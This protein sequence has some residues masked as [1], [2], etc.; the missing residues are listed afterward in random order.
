MKSLTGSLLGT[1]F[2]LALLVPVHGAASQETCSEGSSD[3]RVD[4]LVRL[5][6]ELRLEMQRGVADLTIESQRV[7]TKFDKDLRDAKRVIQESIAEQTARVDGIEIQLG[8]GLEEVKSEI[9]TAVGNL[10]GDEM[11][12]A[13]NTLAGGLEA[14]TEDV[15]VLKNMAATAREVQ[16]TLR[17]DIE[18]G[19]AGLTENIEGILREIQ[20]RE[21]AF[22]IAVGQLN[23]RLDELGSSTRAAGIRFGSGGNEDFGAGETLTLDVTPDSV[24]F[25]TAEARVSP[26]STEPFAITPQ[27]ALHQKCDIAS[28]GPRVGRRVTVSC[29][30]GGLDSGAITISGADLR[31]EN[32]YRYFVLT[33]N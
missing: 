14:L 18:S 27:S 3:E 20:E 21:S 26:R 24:V 29:T 13:V 19:V 28:V 30:F 9:Q 10:R 4:C 16:V 22:S 15:R 6:T 23:V 11:R 8:A 5:V 1:A 2:A 32:S 25:V 33:P 31:G 17:E 7:E 12:S